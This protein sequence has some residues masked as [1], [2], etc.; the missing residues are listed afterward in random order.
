M[1]GTQLHES[2]QLL[3]ALLAILLC[4][5]PWALG[6]SLFWTQA[7]ACVLSAAVFGAALLPRHGDTHS[8]T[9]AGQFKRLLAFPVFWLGL[10][11]LIYVGI[12][13]LNTAWKLEGT[14]EFRWVQDSRHLSWLPAGLAAP[15]AEGGAFRWLLIF[16]T[17]FFAV[18]G[19]WIGLTRRRSVHI[20]LSIVAVN[21]G[22]LAFVGFH[23]VAK[24]GSRILGF[25]EPDRDIFLA[26]FPNHWQA[27]AYFTLILAVSLGMAAHHYLQ[28]RKTFRR[29]NPSGLFVFVA[30]VLLLLVIFSFS[31]AAAALSGALF[32]VFL[33]AL[34]YREF[35]R[36]APRSRK[37]FVMGLAAILIIAGGWITGTIAGKNLQRAAASRNIEEVVSTRE[38]WTATWAAGVE[39]VR[40]RPLFGWGAGSFPHVY[41]NAGDEAGALHL[42]PNASMEYGTSDWIRLAAELGIVGVLLLLGILAAVGRYYLSIRTVQVPVVVFLLLGVLAGLLLSFSS[43]LADNLAFSATWSLLFVLGAILLRVEAAARSKA[44]EPNP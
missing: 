36:D 11:L 8:V 4:F 6:G 13:A 2:E 44:A 22:I 15:L 12:Q 19:A 43:P 23:Q 35:T 25:Y 16:A 10:A 30:M 20:L 5:L 29:S 17:S 28:A 32:L 27:A 7:V 42:P 21:A 9:S 3:V 41:S 18:C 40:Q 37:A 24:G 26:T 1:F 14:G 39:L 33:T 38:G 34:G 31:R